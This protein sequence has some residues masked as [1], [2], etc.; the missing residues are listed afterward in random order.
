MR[1]VSRSKPEGPKDS[2]SSFRIETGSFLGMRKE[3]PHLRY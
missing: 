2:E 1:A 3:F